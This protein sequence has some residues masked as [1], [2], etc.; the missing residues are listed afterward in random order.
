MPYNYKVLQGNRFQRANSRRTIQF[1]KLPS[2]TLQIKNRLYKREEDCSRTRPTTIVDSCR[3]MS[4]KG[5]VKASEP[6]QGWKLNFSASTSILPQS[7]L[8]LFASHAVLPF[9]YRVHK[10]VGTYRATR[11]LTKYETE[12]DGRRK[13]ENGGSDLR[14]HLKETPGTAFSFFKYILGILISS[15]AP[16]LPSFYFAPFRGR[17][18]RICK[19][20]LVSCD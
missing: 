11:C 1:S 7:F 3:S 10:S 15:I 13:N 14:R 4:E 2:T 16:F 18:A 17:V 20:S 19:W 12:E 9:P 8:L 5:W 6:V